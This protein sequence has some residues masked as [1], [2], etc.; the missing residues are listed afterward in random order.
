MKTYR[1]N[2]DGLTRTSETYWN[3]EPTPARRVLV[4][5]GKAKPSWWCSDLEGTMR[6]AVEVTYNGDVFFLDNEDNSAWAKV[7]T[8]YGSPSYGHRSLPQTSVVVAL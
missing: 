7:T 4:E 6:K 1:Y 8:G 5:V 3:G 2:T